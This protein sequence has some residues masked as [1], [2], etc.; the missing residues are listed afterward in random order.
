MG[1]SKMKITLCLAVLLNVMHMNYSPLFFFFSFFF[2]EKRS[3]N[4]S[5]RF[6]SMIQAS[7]ARNTKIM[8]KGSC[9]CGVRDTSDLVELKGIFRNVNEHFF[10]ELSEKS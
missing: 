9:D 5:E 1:Q 10:I 2:Y 7:G 4:F 6:P 3:A 8:E